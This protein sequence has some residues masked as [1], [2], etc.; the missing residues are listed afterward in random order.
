M[1]QVTSSIA[2]DERDIAERFVRSSG[3]GGQN[4]NRDAT[5]VELRLDI[6]KSSLPPDVK[7]RLIALGGRHVTTDGVV[8]VGRE[9]RSQ[10]ENRDAARARLVALVKRAATPPKK[11]N[12]TQPSTVERERRRTSKARVSA[13]KRARRARNED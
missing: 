2:L 6:G 10:V 9:H 5:A 3:P 8:V 12:A 13:V 7:A 1:I 4:L 11:R